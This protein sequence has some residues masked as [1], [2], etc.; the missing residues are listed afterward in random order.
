MN[1]HKSW[2]EKTPEE[3]A[4]A[5]SKLKACND[6]SYARMAEI[7]RIASET[8]VKTTHVGYE[9]GQYGQDYM[10]FGKAIGEI[11]MICKHDLGGDFPDY[12]WMAAMMTSG[13]FDPDR[14]AKEL[15]A[16]ASEKPVDYPVGGVYRTPEKL[17]AFC[18]AGRPAARQR[19]VT[20][21]A[22]VQT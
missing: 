8:L 2:E 16:K 14:L 19:K 9:P 17:A 11:R 10:A 13:H 4:D 7:N 6:R 5:A 21:S 3:L 12:E 22:R 15:D 20:T 18:A 1:E